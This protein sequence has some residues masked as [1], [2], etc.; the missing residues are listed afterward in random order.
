MD[1]ISRRRSHVAHIALEDV[2]LGDGVGRGEAFRCAYAQL[3]DGFMQAGQF[4]VHLHVPVGHVALVGHGDGVFDGFAQPGQL[5]L[6]LVGG[7]YHLQ[8]GVHIV[9]FVLFLIAAL[10]LLVGIIRFALGSGFVYHLAVENILLGYHICKRDFLGSAGR[11]RIDRGDHLA[12]LG[13][14]AVGHLDIL[15]RQVAGVGYG[16]LVGDRFAQRVGFAV[17]RRAGGFLGHAQRAVGFFNFFGFRFHGPGGV[18]PRNRRRVAHGSRQNIRLGHH[19]LR[20]DFHL[21]IGRK[22]ENRGRMAVLR[23]AVALTRHKDG[24]GILHNDVLHDCRAH[25]LHRDGEG[26]RIAQLVIAFHLLGRGLAGSNLIALDFEQAGKQRDGVVGRHVR[27]AGLDGNALL[28]NRVIRADQRLLILPVI[29]HFGRHGIAVQQAFVHAVA[30]HALGGM[31]HGA[32][33]IVIVFQVVRRDSHRALADGQRAGHRLHIELRGHVIAR[34]ILHDGRAPHRHSAA[35]AH[36]GGGL[37]SRQAG[38]GEGLLVHGEDQLLQAF[39][40]Q[41]RA[42]IDLAAAVGF[43]RKAI[44]LVPVL[45]GQL[46]GLIGNGI[47]LRLGIGFQPMGPDLVRAG[48]HQRLAAFHGDACQSFFAHKRALGDLITVIGQRRA[49]IDLFGA[50]GRQLDGHGLHRQRAILALGKGVVLGHVGFPMHDLVA[51]HT[52]RAA[53]RI[54]LTAFHGGGQHIAVHQHALGVGVS[55]VGQRRAVIGLFFAGSGDGD[56]LFRDGID[57]QA[58]VHDLEFHGGE[59]L[60]DVLKVLRFDTHGVFARVRARRRPGGGFLRGHIGRDIH[61]VQGVVGRHGRIA[62]HAVR[63]A[64]IGHGAALFGYRYDDLAG[65]GGDGQL[66]LFFR[67]RVVC[68]HVL[69]AVHDLRFVFERAGVFAHVGA[70]GGV[71]HDREGVALHQTALGDGG[72]ALRFAVIHLGSGLAGKGHRAL[73]DDQRAGQDG[74]GVVAGHILIAG[75]DLHVALHHVQLVFIGARVHGGEGNVRAG[76]GMGLGLVAHGGIHQAHAVILARRIHRSLIHRVRRISLA[77]VLAIVGHGIVCHGNGQGPG[78]DLQRA[79]DGF[80][81]GVVGRHILAR[82]VLHAEAFKRIELAAHVDQIGD[83]IAHDQLIALRQGAMKRLIGA[84]EGAAVID[85]AVAQ[86]FDHHRPGAPGDGKLALVLHDVIV[87]RI[88]I[89]GGGVFDGVGHLAVV[90]GAVGHVGHAAGS[91]N[92]RHLALH[93]AVGANGHLGH[94]Q[95]RAVVFLALRLRGQLHFAGIDLQLARFQHDLIVD[96][97]ERSGGGID[98]GVG[99]HAVAL[100]A[101]I[102]V[103]HRA[104]GLVII[105]FAVDDVAGAQR[106][107]RARQR[108]AGIVAAGAIAGEHQLLGSNE[109]VGGALGGQSVQGGLEAHGIHAVAGGGALHVGIRGA[110]VQVIR[111]GGLIPVFDLRILGFRQGAGIVDIRLGHHAVGV[112][113]VCVLIVL[114]AHDQR[115]RGGGDL[116]V[117][118]V[119]AD[120]VVGILDAQLLSRLGDDQHV[121]MGAHGVVARIGA[122]N[123]QVNARQL[124]LH[125]LVGRDN[126]LALIEAQ[127]GVVKGRIGFAIYLVAVGHFHNHRPLFDFQ[128][129]VRHHIGDTLEILIDGYEIP[130][131]QA[132]HVLTHVGAAGLGQRLGRF[133]GGAALAIGKVG[134][135]VKERVGAGGRVALHGVLMG[136]IEHCRMIAHDRHG[137]FG[138]DRVD[139]Q[140]A[141]HD[142]EFHVGEI[143]VDVLKVLRFD[144]HGVFA[145]VGALGR[146]GGS[147]RFLHA[148]FHIVQ[149]IVRRDGFITRDGMLG[150]VIGGVAALFGYRYD[151]LVGYGGNGQLALFFRDRVVCGHVLRAVHDLRFVF[152]RA[153]VF[154]HVGARGGVGHDRE[155]VALHQTALGDGGDALRFAVIHLGS[156]LAGKG[157]RALA[158]GQLAVPHHL[159]RHFLIVKVRV[160]I[161]ELLRLQAHGIGAHVGALRRI[162]AGKGEVCGGIQPVR[163]GN[164]NAIAGYVFFSAIVGIGSGVAGNPHHDLLLRRRNLQSA[165]LNHKLHVGEVGIRVGKVTRLDAHVVFAHFRA[166]RLPGQGDGSVHVGF[167]VVQRIVRRHALVAFDVVLLAVID[168]GGAVFL[169]GYG[170][171]RGDRIDRQRA[172]HDYEFHVVEILVGV[173]K[174]LRPDAHGIFARVRARRRPG[175]GGRFLHAGFHIVQ[176]IVRRDGFI[177]RDGMLGA[178]IGDGVALFSYRHG[179]LVGNWIDYQRTVRRLG[180][181]ILPVRVHR[182]HGVFREGRR[183]GSGVRSPRANLNGAEVRSL[184]SAGEAG[185][186][187]LL[188]VIGHVIALGGQLHVLIVVENDFICFRADGDGLAGSGNR[189]TAVHRFRAFGDGGAIRLPIHRFAFGHRRGG[190]VPIVVNGIAQVSALGKPRNV[191]RIGIQPVRVLVQAGLRRRRRQGRLSADPGFVLIPADERIPRVR[192]RSGALHRIAAYNLNRIPGRA[193]RALLRILAGICYG[194]R[195]LRVQRPDSIEGIIPMAVNENGRAAIETVALAIRLGIPARQRV[196]PTGEGRAAQRGN[197]GVIFMGDRCGGLAVRR[198]AAIAIIGQGDGGGRIPPL[199]GEGHIAG[200]GQLI[201]GLLDF[202]RALHLPADEHLACRRG[203]PGGGLHIRFRAAGI[204]P[205]VLNRARAFARVVGYLILVFVDIVGIQLNILVNFGVE[206]KGRVNIAGLGR[207][208]NELPAVAF[209]RCRRGEIVRVDRTAVGDGNR[210]AAIACHG[211]EGSARHRRRCPLGVDGDILGGHFAGEL[212]ERLS[213]GV[214]IPALEGIVLFSHGR[215]RRGL[216]RRAGDGLLKEDA[217]P[218]S[219]DLAAAVHINNGV[220]VAGVIEFGVI[221]STASFRAYAGVKRIAGNGIL[222]LHGDRVSRAGGGV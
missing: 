215:R 24:V 205:R 91:P 152:E 216:V 140:H 184:G 139:L 63:L 221:V 2:L 70:R 19:M 82:R 167:H 220:A 163:I 162:A 26:D 116:K 129:A 198:L 58:A 75:Q 222:I 164:G 131:L 31:R 194:Y 57:N 173:F 209:R 21:R 149:R 208:G 124:G 207:P 192:G 147:G 78:G 86:G 169:Y 34:R 110:F 25:V 15:R 111:A 5:A 76:E 88:E 29:A 107:V 211:D 148:G 45:H 168:D 17:F 56:G 127:R 178:V 195:L 121:L 190:T 188:A 172:I 93:K 99:H 83:I 104:G 202:A 128:I 87:P 6:L 125:L 213:G 67:D 38:H 217:R 66:A 120:K 187:M 39:H 218:I 35:F 113:V 40:L 103:G 132:H 64:V 89:P 1:R 74:D 105:D 136:V 157:H 145:R 130:A 98:D 183:I 73:A 144:A 204:A 42:V 12:L 186:G 55:A 49:V 210:C 181:D 53:A 118:G 44:L 81:E 199:G 60:A 180:H 32:F 146:P 20:L 9:G 155:G 95:G 161:L 16:D 115:F 36:V 166:L 28:H 153:G 27:F 200:N 201:A 175:G 141:V 158:D 117:A 133:A 69:R 8:R 108:L 37:F 46:A 138:L 193:Y 47:V 151:D 54:G 182:A 126:L 135:H 109:H 101:V 52:V 85:L 137:H 185:D 94:G 72:D 79:V 59:I 160:R 212:M 156:G 122:V 50:V 119:H 97:L 165:V 100:F 84:I 10:R 219:G 62:M 171:L 33:I 3:V 170:N 92:I 203:E 48:A 159:E 7:L 174:V 106:H 177:T 96:R 179:D 134:I 123:G 13:A 142:L 68:G 154:A 90:V 197:G 102:G 114:R 80:A 150:A 23:Y 11:Q 41:G 18:F 143:L 30:L 77:V 206:I 43:H 176:R 196:A 214:V 4:V 61:V 191:R 112:A 14:Q 71:G 65:Y 189:R 22:A 51:R